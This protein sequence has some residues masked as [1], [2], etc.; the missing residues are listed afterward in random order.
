MIYTG[1]F[2]GTVDHHLSGHVNSRLFPNRVTE[3]SSDNHAPE[4]FPSRD[5]GVSWAGEW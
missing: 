3:S 5:T 4:R 1:D 2:S